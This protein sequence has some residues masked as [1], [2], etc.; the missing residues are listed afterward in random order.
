ME[1]VRRLVPIID[2]LLCVVCSAIVVVFTLL[3]AVQVVLRYAWSMPLFWVEELCRFLLIY[4][5]F[6]GSALAWGRRDHISIDFT[7]DLV[8]ERV[9]EI[10]VALVD[11]LMLGFSVWAVYAG[12]VYVA[13]SMGRASIS[14]GVANGYAYMG[15]PV[16]FTIIAVQSVVFLLLR[17]AHAP[18]NYPQAGDA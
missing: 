5:T 10:I 3:L 11:L 8:G 14:L 1:V 17:F 4:L 2:A 12:S 9:R 13:A 15:V 18:E 7:L 16:A 6:L